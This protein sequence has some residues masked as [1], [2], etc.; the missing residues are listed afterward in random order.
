MNQCNAEND[1]L[2]AARAIQLD[3][4]NKGF[5]WPDIR[6]V[7]AKVREEVDEVEAAWRAGDAEHARHELGDLLFSA[8]N[9]ARFLNADSGTELERASA[10]FTRRFSMLEQTL[11]AKN[12]Q[13]E[14]CTM[15]ELD[16]VWEHV[17]NVLAKPVSDI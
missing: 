10:K 14:H 6:G 4:A 16:Q 13:L 15:E 12:I 8:V 17:K 11:S 7:F 9:L 3:A 1:V 5:D 2:K